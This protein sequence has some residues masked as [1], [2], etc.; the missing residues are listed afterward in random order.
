[1]YHF[2]SK[3]ISFLSLLLICNCSQSFADIFLDEWSDSPYG[4]SFS[5]VNEFQ[6]S[7]V[8][9]ANNLGYIDNLQEWY[10]FKGYTIG[11]YKDSTEKV[12]YFIFNES[13]KIKIVFNSE[14]EQRQ[15]VI[16]NELEPIFI[17]RAFDYNWK[18]IA[19]P[20]TWEAL[21]FI[22]ILAF[23][24]TVP[25]TIVLIIIIYSIRNSKRFHRFMYFI[26]ALMMLR[27]FLD[28]YP[29]SF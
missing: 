12:K 25:L 22:Y 19:N 7:S 14:K 20:T 3:K 17:K 16:L 21:L 23:I 24:V 10:F 15:Y 4:S 18:Y 26:I 27:V 6:T 5:F 29:Q 1:M 2:I 11:S 8:N 9:I 28:I 13:K